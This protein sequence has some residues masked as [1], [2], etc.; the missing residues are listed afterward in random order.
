MAKRRVYQTT[1]IARAK[2]AVTKFRAAK[3]KASRK[4]LRKADRAETQSKGGEMAWS[5]SRHWSLH[6][7][8]SPVQGPD[9][10]Y[11]AGCERTRESQASIH[12]TPMQGRDGIRDCTVRELMGLLISC[13][14]A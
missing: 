3:K 8:Q 10:G 13:L 5:G 14:P 7:L 4:A 2:A 12:R 9:D 1:T 11:E 6:R